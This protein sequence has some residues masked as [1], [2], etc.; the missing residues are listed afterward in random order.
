MAVRKEEGVSLREKY[1]TFLLIGLLVTL[2]IFIVAFRVDMTGGDSELEVTQEQE[3]IDMEEIQQ[4]EQVEEPPPPPRP[5][6]PEEVPDDAE[7]TDDDL[8]LDASLDVDEPMEDTPPPPDEDDDGDDEPEIFEVVEDMPEPI[9]GMAAIQEAIEYP[10]VAQRA[11][12]EGRVIV[13]FT[14]DEQGQTSDIRVVRGVGSG[15]DEEAMRVIQEAEFEPGMQRGEAVPV[16][17]TLPIT[18]QLN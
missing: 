8:D 16:R 11:G 3:V 6:V 13:E 17:M 4:T 7:L 18:F 2:G 15:L 5:P 1:R 9:G 14:V 10:Q 12:V